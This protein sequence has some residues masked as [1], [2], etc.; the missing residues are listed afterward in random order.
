MADSLKENNMV[1]QQSCSPENVTSAKKEITKLQLELKNLQ[2]RHTAL[3]ELNQLSHDCRTLAEFYPQV[4]AVIAS[5]ITAPNFF[6]V[7]YEQT[8]S[9]L[10]FVFSVDEN[11][12]K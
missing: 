7:M 10:E 5:L 11:Q 12:Y 1:V 3:F 6:I 8:F 4:H 2:V 9:T